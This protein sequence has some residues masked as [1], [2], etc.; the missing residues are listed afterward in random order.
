M[1]SFGNGH[2]HSVWVVMVG[3]NVKY[4]HSR[5]YILEF[6][7][8]STPQTLYKKTNDNYKSLTLK[9]VSLMKIIIKI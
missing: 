7:T 3:V 1:E 8:T 9:K 2:V 6:P 5:I 4:I